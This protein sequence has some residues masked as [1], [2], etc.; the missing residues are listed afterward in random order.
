ML[1]LG[2][3]FGGRSAE[4]DISILS[5]ASVSDA[6]DKKKFIPIHIGINRKGQW[7]II[8]SD[9]SNLTSLEDKRIET[10]I[11]GSVSALNNKA[12]SQENNQASA[13]CAKP[14]NPGDLSKH[15]DFAL[16]LLHGPYGE[17]GKIQGLFEMLDIP[18]GGSGVTASALAMD[19]LF[20]RD[21]FI[22]NGLPVCRHLSV[23]EAD[24]REDRSSVL[25][26]IEKE[27]GFP[28][29]IKP[30]NLG[31]SVGISKITNP[32][33][34]DTALETAF[35]FDY[36]VVVEEAIDAMEL[37]IAMLGNTGAILGTS[38][39]PQDH[40]L[41]SAGAA[42]FS[43]NS[44]ASDR[45]NRTSDSTHAKTFPESSQASDLLS[46]A[47]YSTH[48]KAFPES[49]QAS[50]RSGQTS[51][52]PG[53]QAAA[54]GEIK[55]DS[56]FYDYDAKYKSAGTQMI[57]PAEIPTQIAEQIRSLAVSAYKS[58]NCEGFARVDFFLD[59]K[60]GRIMVNEIN[61]IPG[62]TRYSMF[63]LLWR[64]AGV[65]YPVLIER[66]IGLGYERYYTKNYREANHHVRQ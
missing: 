30:A 41:Y 7:F 19:K 60:S 2:I 43:D 17:D 57:I 53:V 13:T 45:S 10:L 39:I 11:P 52:Y 49:S 5:A 32:K 29:F 33:H 42:V 46:R 38:Y 66:I 14:L 54:V 34:L 31:S 37:E 8:D 65:E 9:M 59:R 47:A 22:R 51:Y 6:V 44:Q 40:P 1:K 63:P 26:Y 20:A 58:L 4:H 56:E 16:P 23:F 35:S 62:F 61:T 12:D 25:T 15:I 28:V 64:A 50:D 3:L 27:I 55:A 24:Y 36:R 48:P 18:Y 21:V